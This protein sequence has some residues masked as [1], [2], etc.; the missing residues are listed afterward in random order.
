MYQRIMD[1]VIENCQVTFEEDGVNQQTLDEL[2]KVGLFSLLSYLAGRIF[3]RCFQKIRYAMTN[4]EA[5][6]SCDLKAIRISMLLSFDVVEDKMHTFATQNWVGGTSL[7]LQFS[8][9]EVRPF[10]SHFKRRNF[11]LFLPSAKSSPDP[12][13]AER[14]TFN[15]Y[16]SFFLRTMTK[17]AVVRLQLK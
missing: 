17:S 6:Y 11:P 16:I 15:F 3:S 14:T 13:I 7:I 8:A 12:A 10:D 9:G 2:R 1:D 4:V 5:F